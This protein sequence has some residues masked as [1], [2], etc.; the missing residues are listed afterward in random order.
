MNFSALGIYFYFLWNWNLFIEVFPPRVFHK[1]FIDL[2]FYLFYFISFSF[3][4][5]NY[6]R[7]TIN[8]HHLS[9]VVCLTRG[10][11][12]PILLSLQQ[13]FSTIAC[14]HCPKVLETTICNS[15]WKVETYNCTSIFYGREYY[16]ILSTLSIF[17]VI[18]YLVSLH[19][20]SMFYLKLRGNCV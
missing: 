15:A 4:I 3:I 17:L 5:F 10:Y 6:V 19:S 8:H 7:I 9:M 2:I 11:L 14:I 18:I 13:Q 1:V 20:T 12:W 16:A